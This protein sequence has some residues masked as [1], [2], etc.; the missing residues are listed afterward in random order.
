VVVNRDRKLLFGFVLADNVLIKESFNLGRLGKMYVLWRRL[1]VLVFV[2]DV[3]ANR[4]ALITD[5][6]RGT[7]DQFTDVILTLVA[8]RAS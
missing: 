8:E 7:R 3:L 1:V 4:Y 5:E 2:D 6:N